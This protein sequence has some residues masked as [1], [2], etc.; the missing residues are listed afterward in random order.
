MV[1]QKPSSESRVTW[2]LKI[3]SARVVETS[4]AKY[5]PSQDSGH[6]DD[7]FR[8]RYVDPGFKPFSYKIST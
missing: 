2:T 8:S 3:A 4:V 1:M 7:H 6:P 5:S